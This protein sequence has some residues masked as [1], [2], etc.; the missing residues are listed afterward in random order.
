MNTTTKITAVLIAGFV[1]MLFG[2]TAEAKTVEHYEGNYT[3]NGPDE[4][5]EASAD[6]DY[7]VTEKNHGRIVKV[8][9]EANAHVEYTYLNDDD[10]KEFVG[11]NGHVDGVAKF[12]YGQL[13][14]ADINVNGNIYTGYETTHHIGYETYY[15][16]GYRYTVEAYDMVERYEEGYEFE[17][18][19]KVRNYQIRPASYFTWTPYEQY[20]YD[21]S[22][23]V[24]KSEYRSKNS[25]ETGIVAYIGLPEG[26]VVEGYTRTSTANAGNGIVM[27]VV[28]PGYTVGFEPWKSNPDRLHNGR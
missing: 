12:K 28:V 21:Y 1:L 3:Y 25:L 18:Y 13:K 26:T 7:T 10:Y 17:G 23:K 8:E 6:W 20:M 24:T 9:G 15:Q 16:D 22:A 4:N 14:K 19:L 11:A 2:V 27:E 5:L